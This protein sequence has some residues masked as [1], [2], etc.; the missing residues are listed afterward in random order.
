MKVKYGKRGL[1]FL[2]MILGM[3]LAL[4]GFLV[5]CGETEAENNNQNNGGNGGTTHTHEMTHHAKV[6]STC[7]TAGT[8]EYWSCAGCGKNF[9]DAQGSSEVTDLAL[10]LAAH[11]LS[12][13]EAAEPTCVHDGNT[14]HWH[15]SVCD[16]NFEDEDGKTEAKDVVI[17]ADGTSHD[18]TDW[19]YQDDATCAKDGTKKRTCQNE[20]CTAEETLPMEGTKL[21][22][23]Y[24]S[25]G[26]C[27]ECGDP[28]GYK[29]SDGKIVVRADSLVEFGVYP[30]SEVSDKTIK[31]E[32]NTLAGKWSADNQNWIS[33][34]YYMSGAPS[35]I[36]YYT[37]QIYGNKKYRGVYLQGVRPEYT[38]GTGAN[39]TDQ[40]ENGYW[41]GSTYWFEFEPLLWRVIQN[42]EDGTS[43]LMSDVII[44]SQPF[45]NEGKNG[46]FSKDGVTYRQND[47]SVSSIHQ[48]LN[49]EF[50]GWAFGEKDKAMIED[51]EVTVDKDDN[52]YTN[53]PTCD[54]VTG[55]VF[56]LSIAQVTSEPFTALDKDNYDKNVDKSRA[57][58]GT[59]YAKAQGL[60]VV[61]E[62]TGTSYWILR[63][64][65]A[66]S[67]GFYPHHVNENGNPA[68]FWY[69][70]EPLFSW[71]VYG[72]IV[73]A[74]R[75]KLPAQS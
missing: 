4:C 33:Y 71:Y 22:H 6:D 1:L 15:C 19:V 54:P 53:D 55:K 5:G 46:Y 62:D 39:S 75:I 29:S 45:Q 67:T 2:A 8:K 42:E 61:N 68:T 52:C 14:E 26:V 66:L 31:D 47:Y 74:L 21:R 49:N 25:D 48:W 27:T 7:K 40:A 43:L 44:D 9:S 32:L 58:T 10:P 30:Q 34:G 59:P 38:S 11:T 35:D 18:W 13:V 28:N 20:D 41:V 73:P 57:L 56:L 17:K 72:G 69:N 70:H 60:R 24:N 36:M 37:D 51:T 50:S 64:A 3:V 16:K 12:K 23:T 65:A 63:T